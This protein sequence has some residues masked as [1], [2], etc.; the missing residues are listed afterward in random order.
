MIEMLHRPSRGR[1]RLAVPMVLVHGGYMAAWVWDEHLLPHLATAGIDAWAPSLRGH[2]GEGRDRLDSFDLDDY[3]ADL[4][5]VV[6]RMEAPP[7]LVGH[8]MGA[9]VVQRYLAGGGRATAAML[10]APVPPWGLGAPSMEL[11]LRDPLLWTEA[12]FLHVGG[13]RMASLP[14][15]RRAL[16]GA[17]VDPVLAR[18]YLSR[19][20]PES[21]LAIAQMCAM[22]PLGWSPGGAVPVAVTGG[23]EDGLF[24]VASL[25]ACAAWHGVSATVLDGLGHALMLEPG[26]RGLAEHLVEWARA[27]S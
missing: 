22:A 13:P 9:L 18:T 10:L 20:Q 7:L 3:V 4:G 26:W 24:S 25:R 21:T 14:V 15:L 11:A 2:G 23:R 8:S 6:A 27:S 5:S 12:A 1:A 16:F 19:L 17:G